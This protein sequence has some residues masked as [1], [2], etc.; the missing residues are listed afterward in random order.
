MHLDEIFYEKNLEDM[1]EIA[2]YDEVSRDTTQVE[3]MMPDMTPP[4]ITQIMI[5]LDANNPQSQVVAIGMPYEFLRIQII[6][7]NTTPINWLRVSRS[8]IGAASD[9]ERVELWKDDSLIAVTTLMLDD[10]TAVLM[11]DPPL[12]L[13]PGET[14]TLSVRAQGSDTASGHTAALSIKTNLDVGIDGLITGN[15]PIQGNL[16]SFANAMP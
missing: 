10:D 3:I 1:T 8:G 4:E 5:S 11:I 6:V 14:I 15:F 12:E 7:S 16:M 9:I 13:L 2:M